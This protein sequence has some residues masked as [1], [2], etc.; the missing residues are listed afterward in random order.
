MRLLF[1]CISCKEEYDGGGYLKGTL[2]SEE[3]TQ[4]VR[5]CG[6][7]CYQ[8]YMKENALFKSGTNYQNKHRSVK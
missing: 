1:V 3:E 7:Q 5:L 6:A 2:L 4:F 8:A